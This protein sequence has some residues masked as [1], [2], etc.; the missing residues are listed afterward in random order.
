M[1]AYVQHVWYLLVVCID[2]CCGASS[3]ATGYWHRAA[4]SA[5]KQQQNQQQQRFVRAVFHVA[6]SDAGSAGI[7]VM[8]ASQSHAA[9]QS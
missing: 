3:W 1:R 7:T 8:L 5:T 2:F 4:A 9:K 6:K